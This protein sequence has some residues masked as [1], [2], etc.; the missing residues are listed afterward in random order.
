MKLL[1]VEV[2]ELVVGIVFGVG[3]HLAVLRPFPINL[4]WSKTYIWTQ[5]LTFYDAWEPNYTFKRSQNLLLAL[6]LV[7][8]STQKHLAVLRSFPINL[9][10]SKTYIWNK[11]FTFYDAWEPNYTLKRSYNLLLAS[12]LVLVSTQKHYDDFQSTLMVESCNWTPKS[13]LHDVWKPSYSFNRSLNML[14]ALL[15]MLVKFF[16][17][18]MVCS[19]DIDV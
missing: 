9:K 4:E 17:K 15:L 19:I 8:M 6:L 13:T 11:K 12:L 14:L 7:L 3:V 5:K 10:W 18:K 1:F 16:Q 2:L